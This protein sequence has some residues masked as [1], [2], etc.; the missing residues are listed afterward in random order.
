MSDFV[1]EYILPIWIIII[2]IFSVIALSFGSYKLI[3]D[4]FNNKCDC[5]IV[6]KK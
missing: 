1:Y 3:K 2:A 5:I 4:E 6:N